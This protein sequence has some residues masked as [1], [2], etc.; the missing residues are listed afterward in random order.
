MI[1]LLFICSIFA[2]TGDKGYNDGVYSGV[3][4]SVY[5]NEHYYG[6]TTIEIINGRIV[7]VAF[8]IRDSSKHVEFDD[9]YEKYFAGNERYME[10]CRKDRIGVKLYPDRLL[11]HQNVNK[12]DALSGATWSYNIFKASVIEALEK[13]Q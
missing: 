4:R 6:H 3:S 12:V 7:D 11:E 1:A 10:Q 13:A 2:F 5:T 9:E 8:V